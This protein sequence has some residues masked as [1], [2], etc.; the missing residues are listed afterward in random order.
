MRINPQTE[1]AFYIVGCIICLCI[2]LGGCA[3]KV[4]SY[5][6]CFKQRGH[7]SDPIGHCLGELEPTKRS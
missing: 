5:G 3:V 2:I 1:S 4:E 7:L 6:Q